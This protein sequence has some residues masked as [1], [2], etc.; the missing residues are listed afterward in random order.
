MKHLTTIV[1]LHMLSRVEHALHERRTFRD[2]PFHAPRARAAVGMRATRITLPN[3]TW[4]S[5]TN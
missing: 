1:Q 4:R 5:T 2:T 3:G